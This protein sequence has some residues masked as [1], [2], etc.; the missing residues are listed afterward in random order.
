MYTFTKIHPALFSS[1]LFLRRLLF[2]AFFLSNTITAAIPTQT[3]PKTIEVNFQYMGKDYHIQG[4]SINNTYVFNAGAKKK[5]SLSTLEWAP[6]IGQKIC[7]QGWVQQLTVALLTSQGYEVTVSFYP[8]ARTISMA[9]KGR[10]DIL[11]PEYF[12]EPAAPSDVIKGTK[13]TD[14][15]ALSSPIPGGP[16][17]LLKRKDFKTPFK[18]ELTVLKGERIGVVRGYQ[19][20]PEFDALMDSDFFHIDNSVDDLMNAIKLSK[21]RVDYIVGDPSVIFFS[22]KTGKHLPESIKKITANNIEVIDPPL[23]Y[24]N[25]H[26]AVSKKNPE[27]KLLLQTLNKAIASFKKDGATQQIINDTKK[28]CNKL[29]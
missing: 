15:L 2:S 1:S 8:W 4:N 12:I 22:I 7:K 17:A 11:F 19:N 6:Y 24:N 23:Q 10:V 25:L 13:R 27:W 20:T 18:G 5:V 16:I 28:Q 29:P 21:K 26:Y 9:E 3:S 14:H